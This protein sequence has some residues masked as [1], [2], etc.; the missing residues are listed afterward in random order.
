MNMAATSAKSR[1]KD[2][3]TALHLL[4]FKL[5]Q[6]PTKFLKRYLFKKGTFFPSEL[7]NSL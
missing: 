7:A 3:A 1:E 4:Q 2:M 6:M 5:P